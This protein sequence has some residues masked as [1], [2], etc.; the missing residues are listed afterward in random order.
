MTLQVDMPTGVTS[1]SGSIH[2]FTYGTLMRGMW[3]EPYRQMLSN[4][5]DLEH[6]EW[7]WMTPPAPLADPMHV[8]IIDEYGSLSDA[9]YQTEPNSGAWTMTLD[10]LPAHRRPLTRRVVRMNA[11]GHVLSEDLYDLRNGG[12]QYAGLR[13]YFVYEDIPSGDPTPPP[14]P[15]WRTPRSPGIRLVERHTYSSGAAKLGAA[16]E[17]EGLTII[18]AYDDTLDANTRVGAIGVRRGVG[19]N[20]PTLWTCC[21]FGTRTTRTISRTRCSSS[22]PGTSCQRIHM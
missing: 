1:P 13:E 20:Q 22:S 5:T 7:S 4:G 3:H 15:L 14:R 17:T 21:G 19:E 8:A 18:F 11:A 12:A 16:G 2:E 9:A 10:Q 6:P